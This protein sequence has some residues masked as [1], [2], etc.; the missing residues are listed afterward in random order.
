MSN[1]N[2]IQL[3][4]F[5]ILNSNQDVVVGLINLDGYIP[6]YETINCCIGITVYKAQNIYLMSFLGY[7]VVTDTYYTKEVYVKDLFYFPIIDNIV[8]VLV[9]NHLLTIF[10]RIE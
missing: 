10:S 4:L 5:L 7:Y 2:Y 3:L 1:R 8:H 6:Y 9:N